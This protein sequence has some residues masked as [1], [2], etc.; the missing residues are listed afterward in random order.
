MKY[1]IF[2]LLSL[3]LFFLSCGSLSY[4][5]LKE[6]IKEKRKYKENNQKAYNLLCQHTEKSLRTKL[7]EMS[8]WAHVS[9]DQ[10]GVSMLRMIRSV[11][12]KN[13]KTDVGMMLL[14]NAN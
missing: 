4:C 7:E 12:H 10:D 3:P 9:A 13:D 11:L 14:V 1:R 2:L 5:G 6:V 8:D